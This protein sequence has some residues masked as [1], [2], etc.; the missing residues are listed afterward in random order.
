MRILMKSPFPVSIVYMV[1]I[2]V[3]LKLS[4]FFGVITILRSVVNCCESILVFD[5]YIGA[6]FDEES[7]NIDLA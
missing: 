6:I 4:V 1:Q 7:G 3:I 5:F 2:K